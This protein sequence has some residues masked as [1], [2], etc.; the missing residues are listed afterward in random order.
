M[1]RRLQE[2][3]KI[4][5]TLEAVQPLHVGG[6]QTVAETD[7]PLAINGQGQFY[8]P[9]TSLAGVFRHWL[10]EVFDEDNETGG[11]GLSHRL[12]G[13]QA[14]KGN[15]GNQ[16]SD[17]GWASF[18]LVEDG[19]VNLPDGVAFPQILDSVG[20]DRQS[21][22]AANGIKFDRAIL[23]RGTT[24]ALEMTWE[25][26]TPSNSHLKKDPNETPAALGHLLSQLQEYGLQLGAGGSRG[27]GQVRLHAEPIIAREDWSSRAGVL[28]VLK[29]RGKTSASP[30]WTPKQLQ[31]RLPSL[32]PKLP[33]ELDV[34]IQWRP[35]G[36]LM[37]KAPFD[38]IAVDA[39]PLLS[40]DRDEWTMFLAGSSIKGA[41]RSQAERIVRTLLGERLQMT[42][43]DGSRNDRERHRRQVEVPLIRE[44]FGAAA[45][46][47]ANISRETTTQAGSLR[48]APCYGLNTRSRSGWNSIILADAVDPKVDFVAGATPL[49]QAMSDFKPS[50][51]VQKPRF[52]AATHVAIDRWTGGAAES[53]LYSGFEP[54]HVEWDPLR[55]TLQWSRIPTALR[56]PALALVWL[57]IRDLVQNR[58]PLGFG[59]TRG[60]GSIA[61]EAIQ[62]ETRGTAIDELKWWNG[63]RLTAG[64]SNGVLTRD[65][66]DKFAA[67]HEEA[68]DELQLH[69][70]AAIED[71]LP[72]STDKEPA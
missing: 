43:P 13:W 12:F 21:G 46:R 67:S 32:K 1:A 4:R 41:I 37:S 63:H 16:A 53:L 55:L 51:A 18:V 8:V 23:P 56:H 29:S 10:A 6:A 59:S 62:F 65:N 45:Q 68:F 22:A 2:R 14:T 44:V 39:L 9:G 36:P 47:A 58:I 31:D 52:E 17:D 64:E 27:L 66:L 70:Q 60:Y 7:M 3:W 49:S 20:I 61:V 28:N 19:L 72:R 15:S 24:V 69:W 57:L 11:L 54:R 26:P 35:D 71:G 25:V 48:V 33:P 42:W 38:G 50:G 40:Q 5:G 34:T 30:H